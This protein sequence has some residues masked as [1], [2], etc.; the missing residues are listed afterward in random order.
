MKS[1]FGFLVAS[2]P[3]PSDLLSVFLPTNEG[4]YVGDFFKK[5]K[6]KTNFVEEIK[7]NCCSRDKNSKKSEK[8]EKNQGYKGSKN[9]GK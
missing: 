5:F 9:E 7:R 6:P 2:L 8:D 3:T 1:L 4:K